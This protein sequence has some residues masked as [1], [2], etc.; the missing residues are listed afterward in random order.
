MP[1]L[2]LE[3][4]CEL[5]LPTGE[6]VVGLTYFRDYLIAVTDCGTV[7]RISADGDVCRL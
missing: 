7:F 2:K 1:D 6:R 5:P 3:V 4:L